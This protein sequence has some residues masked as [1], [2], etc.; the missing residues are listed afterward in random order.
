[1]SRIMNFNI[2]GTFVYKY[3]HYIYKSKIFYRTIT[4]Y[5]RIYLYILFKTLRA[6]YTVTV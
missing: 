6:Q 5:L 4:E 3:A 2:V 1:M